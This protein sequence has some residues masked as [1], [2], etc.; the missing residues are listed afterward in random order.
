MME[1]DLLTDTVQVVNQNNMMENSL[2]NATGK[3]PKCRLVC[4][5]T[6]SGTETSEESAA[7]I[8]LD[9]KPP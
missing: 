8:T 9:N 1:T 5:A 7:S 2:Y 3:L 6:Q 4:D